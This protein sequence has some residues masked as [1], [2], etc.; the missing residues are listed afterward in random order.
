MNWDKINDKVFEKIA[1]TYAA[2]NYK[3]YDWI[4]TGQ[5]WDGNTDASFREEIHALNYYYK[6][7]CEA[8]YTQNSDSSIPK[9]HMDSTL[10]SGVLDG[11][12][13]FIL[14][15]T[16]GKITEDF[17]KRATAILQPHK[18]R[19][20]FVGGDIL[21]E[22]LE[23]KAPELIE[24]YWENT[25]I[26]TNQSKLTLAVKDACFLPAILSSPSLNTTLKKLRVR[27]EYFLYLNIYSSQQLT[28]SIELN[29]NALMSIPLAR[30][31][32]KLMPGNNLYLVQYITKHS[33]NSNLKISLFSEDELILQQNLMNLLIEEDD[34]PY[35]IYSKQH[36]IYQQVYE[37]VKTDIQ[38]N[39]ILHITG[40]EGSGKSF[41]LRH[42]VTAIATDYNEVLNISFSEKE[43]EN[44]SSLC[45]LILFINFGYLYDLSEEAFKKLITGYTNLPVELFLELREGS[46]N[47]IIALNVIDKIITL[48]SDV[49]FALFPNINNAVHRSVTYIIIDDFHKISPKYS[50]ICKKILNEFVLRSFNQILII[51][52]RPKEFYDFSLE[53]NIQK[54]ETASWNLKNISV[55]DVY[56]SIE[57]NFNTEVAKISTLF[58]IPISVLHLE[59]LIKK[60]KEKNIVR[61]ARE[62]R[63]VIFA[64][65]YNDTNI[66]NNQFAVKKIKNCGYLRILYVVYKIETGVPAPLLQTFYGDFF[67]SA[68]INFDKDTLIKEENELLKP[69]HD[70]YVYAFAKMD[71]DNQYM[72][73]LNR[74]LEFCI[75]KNV[76]NPVLFS[77]ILSILIDK[78]NYL[79]NNYL[80]LAKDIC[81][82]YYS[83]SQYIAAQNLAFMLL[84]DFDTTPYIEYKYEDLELLYIY[85][86]VEKYSKTHVG[87]SKYLQMIA[88]IGGVLS[89]TSW[90]K[91]IVYEAHSELITN[92]LYSLDLENFRKEVTYYEIHLKDKTD[93]C[94]AP[95]KINAYLNFLNRLILYSSFVDEKNTLGVYERAYIESKRLARD[96][97]QAYANM[98]YGK[99]IIYQ[100]IEQAIEL[101]DKALPIFEKYKQC[102]KRELDC[103][104]QIIFA[105]FL[106]DSKS[107]DMLYDLQKKALESTYI[108]VYA[109]ITLILLTLELYDKEP[110][111]N[112]ETKLIK[113]QIDYPDLKGTHRLTLFVYQLFTAIYYIKGDYQ[114]QQ[115]FAK[116]HR[117]LAITF[118][119]NYTLVPE[120][121]LQQFK[122]QS[123]A[124]FYENQAM[125]NQCLWLDPR[126]W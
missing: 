52:N 118:S 83:K 71:F 54:N 99:V 53:N 38:Q 91:G 116:K 23:E 95:H 92:Y 48:R 62:K 76:E 108:H 34:S 2:D 112:V 87:S 50:D 49:D 15:V 119:E 66:K 64:E 14:F 63:G 31:E 100:N 89:L 18:I 27:Q 29:T 36:I 6:G 37:C 8:K 117:D 46:Q 110:P 24:E 121:N 25:V 7:W 109:K 107:Y 28:I 97:Y 74:F 40:Y 98:D 9:S 17:M 122:T 57:K 105:K 96:D 82:D 101:F 21:T 11:E 111:E 123:I 1:C 4:P 68:S 33:Y 5:S 79:R 86:Q 88:D 114:Q 13:I 75:A 47:Q 102:K 39:S 22:W 77:N 61:S 67:D 44:A 41:L 120:H 94:S 35:I 80:K 93:I 55:T 81:A 84:P 10:V 73:E 51:G 56:S 45:K 90:Q 124:W 60:L 30:P 72:N 69:Y 70:I 43:A 26:E 20:S 113:L 59:L 106:K 19:V 78:N 3:G 12:V 42:L 104:A 103:K 65:V 32:Y 16:N 58:P 125:D 126:I 115:R 85:A